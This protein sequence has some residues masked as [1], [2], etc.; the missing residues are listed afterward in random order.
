M[1][2]LFLLLSLI[3]IL[4]YFSSCATTFEPSRVV[5]IDYS[6]YGSTDFYISESACPQFEYIPIGS[7]IVRGASYTSVES[8]FNDFVQTCKLKGADGIINLN[9]N[10]YADSKASDG[11]YLI[12]GMAIRRVKAGSE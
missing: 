10:V 8:L 5:V 11:D 9:Y 3:G 2:K 12:K 6:K 1:K 4:I 7:V